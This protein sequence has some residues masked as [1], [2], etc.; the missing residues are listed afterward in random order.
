MKG[1]WLVVF[2]LLGA[3]WVALELMQYQVGLGRY[4]ESPQRVSIRQGGTAI[5]GG[6]QAGVHYLGSPFRRSANLE[7]RCKDVEERFR[8][9]P[10][11]VSTPVCGVEVEVL[12]I[13]VGD[14]L[15]VEVRWPPSQAPAE[16]PVSPSLQPSDEPPEDSKTR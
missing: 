15:A 10:G 2:V 12:A 4:A 11:D 1:R 7:V 13:E 5:V 14:R 9:R 16:E 8:L 6:G 3:G